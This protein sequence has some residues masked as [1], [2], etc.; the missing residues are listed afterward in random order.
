MKTF[1]IKILANENEVQSIPPTEEDW[2]DLLFCDYQEVELIDIDTQKIILKGDTTHNNIVEK[3]NDF[4][5]GMYYINQNKEFQILHTIQ[6]QNTEYLIP[7][8]IKGNLIK[9]DIW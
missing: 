3:I 5:E 8:K 6:I 2:D 4:I 1:A 7:K 9:N